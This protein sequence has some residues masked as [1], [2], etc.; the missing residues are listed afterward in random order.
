MVGTLGALKGREASGRTGK[1]VVGILNPQEMFGLV[2]WVAGGE[3]EQSRRHLLVH[4]LCLAI[5]LW[6]ESMRRLRTFLEPGRYEREKFNRLKK[7]AHLACL[8]LT[9]LAEQLYS[10]F[11]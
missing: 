10:R 11:L 7:R 9:R 5:G 1:G 3:T 8:E 6:V 4:A 2:G